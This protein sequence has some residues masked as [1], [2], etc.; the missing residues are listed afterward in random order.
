[1]GIKTLTCG[2]AAGL[3]LLGA[4]GCSSPPRHP[5]AST[6]VTPTPSDYGID[7][8]QQAANVSCAR[9]L[10]MSDTDQQSFGTAL[11]DWMRRH[12]DL[13]QPTK[14][15]PMRFPTGDQIRVF[16]AALT[17]VCQGQSAPTM[18]NM[19]FAALR[20]TTGDGTALL[21]END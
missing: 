4:A 1:M 5:T 9:W 16:V 2:I 13:A 12:P 6:Q 18:V 11:L 14:T 20:A 19:N 17:E 3:V 21:T 15:V 7:W 8:S 10:A